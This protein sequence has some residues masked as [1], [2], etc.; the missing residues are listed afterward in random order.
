[1]QSMVRLVPDAGS[2]PPV[3]V[4][5]DKRPDGV[6]LSYDEMVSLLAPYGNVEALEIAR[7]LDANVKDLL[8]RPQGLPR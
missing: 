7:D 4:L 3:T 5:I 1:M 8:S 6:H 2:Y